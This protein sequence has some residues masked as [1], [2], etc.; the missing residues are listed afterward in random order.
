MLGI[1]APTSGSILIDGLVPD[2]IDVHKKTGFL[3]ERLNFINWMT[4][5]EFVKF[6]AELCGI[7]KAK[8]NPEVERVLTAVSLQRKAWDQ[9]IKNY[10]RGMLQRVGMAQ[11]LL[12]NP[13]YMF[14]DEP[15]SGLDPDGVTL[16]RSLIAKQ[17][18]NGCSI[19]INS[20]QLDQ[21]EKIC[22][23]VI[24]IK[25]G[26]VV[27]DQNMKEIAIQAG[28]LRVKWS[29]DLAYKV[30][31]EELE[32]VAEST[33]TELEQLDFPTAIFRTGGEIQNSMLIS[34]LGESGYPV[35]EAVP[36]TSKLEQLFRRADESL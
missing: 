22:D 16:F 32:K 15:S 35:A 24:L 5:S 18:D 33:E 2:A 20:H 30:K 7:E 1:L 8:I 3:P 10:S 34:K 11:A 13:Q 12:K 29:S 9:R 17:K 23:R 21:L 28:S 25:S 26:K 14:L 27:A 31:K 4:G 6:H 36:T 19:I